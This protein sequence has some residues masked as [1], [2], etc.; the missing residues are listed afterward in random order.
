M[1]KKTSLLIQLNS[2]QYRSNFMK[3]TQAQALIQDL[4]QKILQYDREYYQQGESS[5]SDTEYDLLMEQLQTLENQFPQFLHANS[6]SQRVSGKATADFANVAHKHPML[7][8]ANVYSAEELQAWVDSVYKK[9]PQKDVS[10]V[11]ELKIDGLAISVLYE[12]GKLIQAITRGNGTV[13]D[14]VTSNVRTIR[15]LPLQLEA[16]VSLEVRGEIYLSHRQ[17]ELLNQQRKEAGESLLKNPR[18]AA[19]GSIRMKDPKAVSKRKLELFLYDLVEGPTAL[20]HEENLTYLSSQGMPVTPSRQLCHSFEDINNFCQLW[21]KK[22]EKLAFD[23]DGIVIKVN[24]LT[25]REELGVRSKS[26]RWATAWKFKAEKVKSRLLGVENSIGRTGSI[27]PVANLEPVQL[28]GTEVKRA[29]LHNYDQVARLGIHEGDTLFLEKGGE[30][31]PKIVGID[32]TQR[33]EGAKALRAPLECPVCDSPLNQ[34]EGE[35]DLR[36]I[37]PSC[38]AILEGVLQHFVS[39]KGMDIQS[40][41]AALIQTFISKELIAS[42]PDI[43]RLREKEIKLTLLEGLGTKSVTKLLQAIEESKS[44]VLNQ[45]IH[46]LGIRYIGEKAAKT[47]AQKVEDLEAFMALEEKDLENLS[48]FGEIMR[49]ALLNWISN[50]TNQQ[51]IKEL[52]TLGVTPTPL[53]VTKGKQAFAEQKV[54]ITGTLS[55]ARTLW[56]KELEAVGF[57]VISA[58]SKKTDYLLCGENAGSKLEKARKFGVQVLSEEEME[59]IL[60][61]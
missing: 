44:I 27:T 46:A 3:T 30:I 13:G 38:P 29:T 43:F 35:V 26:P 31:I 40:F 7:S 1:L 52:I 6:P 28:L 49:P 45:F 34:I 48:D 59:L 9:V 33:I 21:E 10:F 61:R 20:S 60:A 54:V 16:P 17:L 19:A 25:F 15:C 32:Y 36:C 51:M 14:D 8:L 4:T 37:N 12:K 39:K 47:L 5:I 18:N 53:E 22:K 42:I 50:P 56:K 41:G 57:Q 55:K 23:I 24:E 11:C 58:I 2:I